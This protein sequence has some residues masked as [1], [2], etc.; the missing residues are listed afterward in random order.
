[1]ALCREV[2]YFGFALFFVVAELPSGSW[3]GLEYSQSFPGGEFAVCETCRLGWGKC[4][5]TCTENE[6]IAGRCKLNFFCCR[7]R[8]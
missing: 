5:R 2:F 8:I 7:E 4:R 3:A 6:K 1:M